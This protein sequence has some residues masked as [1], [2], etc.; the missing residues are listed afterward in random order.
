[1]SSLRLAIKLSLADETQPWS[2]PLSLK[3]SH[4]PEATA[5]RVVS[6]P[7][8]LTSTGR[9]KS[10]S[11][12]T[13][14]TFH[15]ASSVKF[16]NGLAT[17]A[18]PRVSSYAS[19]EP[20]P[21][22]KVSG[23]GSIQLAIEESIEY[24]APN[25][26]EFIQNRSTNALPMDNTK[27]PSFMD[28]AIVETTSPAVTV[29]EQIPLLSQDGVVCTVEGKQTILPRPSTALV[30]SNC[31]PSQNASKPAPPSGFVS[32]APM[33]QVGITLERSVEINSWGLVFIKEN[34]GLAVIVRVIPPTKDGPTVTWCQ[35]TNSATKP[36]PTLYDDEKRLRDAG[37]LVPYVM[38]GDAIISINGIPISA[39]SNTGGLASYIREHCL[40][41]MTI[42]ALRHEIVW[43]AAQAEISRSMSQEQLLDT[44]A[45]TDCVSKCVSKVWRRVFAPVTGDGQHPAKRKSTSHPT[46]VKRQKITYTKSVFRDGDE[47]LIP[48]CDVGQRVNDMS[49]T[50]LHDFWLVNGYESFDRWHSSSKA[51]WAKSYSWHKENDVDL[52]VLRD[53]WLANGYESFDDWYSTSKTKWAKSYSWHKERRDAFQ[54]TCE[55]EVHH[56]LVA[57]THILLDEFENWLGVR[58]NQWRL[59]R[60]KRQRQRVFLEESKTSS[61]AAN[62][63]YI[64]EM[65]EDQERFNNFEEASEPMDI[66]WIFDSQ[67]G[68]PDDVIANMMLYLRP[69]EH[70]A[71]LCLSYTSNYLFKQRDDMWRTLFPSHWVVP[72]RPRQSWCSMYITKI[73]AEEEAS[74]K[75]SDDL[76]VKAHVIIDN[77][78]QLNKFEKLITKAEKGFEFSV[79]YV[80]GVVLE[81]NSMLNLSVIDQRHKITKWLIE[82]KGADIESCDRGQFTPLMNAAWN[83]M[84][85]LSST[86]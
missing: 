16:E 37:L 69:S 82:E 68:A 76:L 48:F 5:R 33:L 39:F 8:S 70:G 31:V 10:S 21:E 15:E 80:S 32:P 26:D 67:R 61:F 55:K 85:T 66:M 45:M 65:L 56:P 27:A 72:R 29:P 38:V 43:T 19:I 46:T 13:R 35:I 23:S 47:K 7:I 83:G 34:S 79:N 75:R 53:F 41:K 64:D 18:E 84:Y 54:S 58:K 6:S 9:A 50:V 17:T 51:K 3:R 59:E 81:R 28:Y 44:Q 40:R 86:V 24:N 12:Q 11:T 20:P 49:S 71:L 14:A 22:G 36:S 73:R 2:L 74:R 1:M 63:M 77:G 52:T 42:V 25:A 57:C 30:V 4:N 62:D 60:R 78:D